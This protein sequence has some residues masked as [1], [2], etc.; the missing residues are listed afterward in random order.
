L[1][2]TSWLVS[3]VNEEGYGWCLMPFQQNFSYMVAVSFTGG[4]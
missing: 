1:R 2:Q 4:G 3:L